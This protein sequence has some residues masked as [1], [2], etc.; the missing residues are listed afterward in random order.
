MQRIFILLLFIGT[1]AHAQIQFW[2][3]DE[4]ISK[5]FQP[6]RKEMKVKKAY[7]YVTSENWKVNDSTEYNEIFEYDRE[8]RQT[9]YRKY[10]T[11]WVK[12]KRYFLYIDSFFYNGQGIFTGMK[13]YNSQNDGAYYA[14]GYAAV[15]VLNNKGQIQKINYYSGYNASELDKYEVYT[16]DNKNRVSTITSY[17]A[18]GKK[19]NQWTIDYDIQN[20]PI[21]ARSASGSGFIDYVMKYDSDGLLLQYT[22]LYNGTE[23]QGETDYTYDN[24]KRLMLVYDNT[25]SGFSDSTRYWYP[26]QRKLYYWSYFKYPREKGSDTKFA[27]EFRAYKFEEYK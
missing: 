8:G 22:E 18:D 2:T 16:Y 1:V 10:K 13:R 21:K 20:H 6:A 3:N 4:I 19:D 23:K 5:Q 27:H 12:N 26:E 24:D 9:G 14:L 7:N 17:S 11:D 25:S 15:A